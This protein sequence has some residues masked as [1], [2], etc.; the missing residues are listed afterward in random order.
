MFYEKKISTK[1]KQEKCSYYICN[2]CLKKY[3]KKT[4]KY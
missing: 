3:N 1:C 4:N 2:S